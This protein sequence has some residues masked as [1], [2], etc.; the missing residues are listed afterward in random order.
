M[1]IKRPP[2]R[3]LLLLCLVSLMI[4]A[5]VFTVAR[6]QNAQR[7]LPQ[8]ISKVRNIEVVSVTLRQDTP[9]PVVAIEIWN[10]SDKPVIAVAMETGNDHDA[11]GINRNG[12]RGDSPPIPVIDPYGLTTIE[13]GLNNAR[14]GEPIRVAGVIY[15]DGTED[16]QAATLGTMRRQRNHERQRGRNS[17]ATSQG[18][19]Q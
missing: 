12:Y 5:V 16:G 1:K 8:V 19:S 2:L 15:A 7:S 17:N 11:Y 13:M 4:A 14:P 3:S 18:G 10:N 6:Q 9:T